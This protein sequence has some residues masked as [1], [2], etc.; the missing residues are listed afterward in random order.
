M[1]GSSMKNTKMKIKIKISLILSDKMLQT[2]FF[3]HFWID[4]YSENARVIIKK[5]ENNYYKSKT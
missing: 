4:I 5:K 1:N 3:R 2:G